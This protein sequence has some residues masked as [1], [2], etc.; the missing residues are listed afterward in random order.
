M[1]RYTAVGTPSEVRDYLDD[2]ARRADAASAGNDQRPPR[3]SRGTIGLASFTVIG[4]PS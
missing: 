3:L 2:F 1:M 4:R